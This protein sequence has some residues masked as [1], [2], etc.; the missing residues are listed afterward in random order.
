MA[1]YVKKILGFVVEEHHSE[2]ANP[3][4]QFVHREDINVTRKVLGQTVHE[5]THQQVGTGWVERPVTMTEK[6]GT[7]FWRRLL[8]G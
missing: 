8:G 7:P 1:S 6:V 5:E 4:Q 3:G 2:E